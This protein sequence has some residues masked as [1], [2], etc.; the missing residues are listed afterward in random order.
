MSFLN[1]KLLG[2]RNIPQPP[3]C[4]KTG[5]SYIISRRMK[6]DPA[7]ATLVTFEYSNGGGSS[8]FSLGTLGERKTYEDSDHKCTLESPAPLTRLTASALCVSVAC[9]CHA[10]P[11]TRS[12]CPRNED[13]IV[14]AGMF[15]ILIVPDQLAVANCSLLGEKRTWDIGLSSPI[16]D[17]KFAY[18]Y[19]W[20]FV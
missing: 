13:L 18:F 14:H 10:T 19:L 15:H 12:S 9:G 20:D 2:S 6:C 7:N 17:P 3:C 11:P 8:N 5:T 16:W 4:V 1:Q